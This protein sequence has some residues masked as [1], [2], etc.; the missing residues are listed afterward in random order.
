M[1]M[2]VEGKE[3]QFVGYGVR[4]R[5]GSTHYLSDMD[6]RRRLIRILPDT[7]FEPGVFALFRERPRRYVFGGGIFEESGGPR[8]PVDGEWIVLNGHLILVRDKHYHPS[9]VVRL[10][11]LASDQPTEETQS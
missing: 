10:V 5:L 9:Q 8:I 4:G 11:A 3:Y 7:S 6:A 2:T 1:N